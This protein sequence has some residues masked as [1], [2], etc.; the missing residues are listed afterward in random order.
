MNIG[1]MKNKRVVKKLLEKLRRNTSLAFNNFGKSSFKRFLVVHETHID[2]FA[3]RICYHDGYIFK[4]C[5]QSG[6]NISILRVIGRYDDFLRRFR[7]KSYTIFFGNFFGNFS[8]L[9]F[10]RQSGVKE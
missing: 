10:T 3:E 2:V 7:E 8:H 5:L 1:S 6:Q 4:Y 9:F